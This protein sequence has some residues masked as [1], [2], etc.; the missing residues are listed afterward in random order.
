MYMKGWKRRRKEEKKN[1]YEAFHV[2][3]TVR[4]VRLRIHASPEI[5][6]KG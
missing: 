2:R 6:K 3:Y 1:T 4:D 5:P